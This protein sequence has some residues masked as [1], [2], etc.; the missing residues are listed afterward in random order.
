MLSSY[1]PQTSLKGYAFRPFGDTWPADNR[2]EQLRPQERPSAAKA[3]QK[4]RK[5]WPGKSSQAK[6]IRRPA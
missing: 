3:A 1:S 4:M 5:Y 2:L 6:L